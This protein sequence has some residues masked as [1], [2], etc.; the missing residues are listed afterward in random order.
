MKQYKLLIVEDNPIASDMTY[1]FFSGIDLML[2]VG[3]AVNGE[4]A[5]AMTVEHE[6]DVVLLDIVMP[7]SDGFHYL[8]GL[9][10]HP[11]LHPTVI[12][13][14][15]L[16]SDHTIARA[17]EL[18]A[19]FYMIKPVEM[20]AVYRRILVHLGLMRA[21][22]PLPDPSPRGA[23]TARHACPP[24]PA[25]DQDSMIVD[26]LTAIGMPPHVQGY[27]FSR[28]AVHMVAKDHSLLDRLTKDLYPS[29]AKCFDTSTSNIE[30][31]IR[32]ALELTWSRSGTDSINDALGYSVFHTYGR[33]T[34]GEFIASIASLLPHSADIWR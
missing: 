30:R 17:L 4:E 7:G 24:A 25:D 9:A 33:P 10:D 1:S 22:A 23:L 26:V 19:C 14:S 18:G 21:G 32:H 2:P 27:A 28:E 31:S 5:L 29:I 11:H 12:V 3:V 20:D 16:S 15:S 34:N 13:I 8:E 6:P